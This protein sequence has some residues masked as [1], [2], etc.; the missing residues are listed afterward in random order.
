MSG[1]MVPVD[2]LRP[3]PSNIRTDL[4]DLRELAA[5]IR[6]VGLLQPLVV[7]ANLGGSSWTVLDGHRRLGAAKLAGVKAVPCLVAQLGSREHQLAI[8]L[9]AAMHKALSVREQAAAFGALR[10][11]GLA[12]AEIGRRTGYS[13]STVSARLLL[14]GLPDEALDL[15]DGHDLTVTEATNLAR[16]VH[17]TGIGATGHAAPMQQ[18]FAPGHPLWTRV[19]RGC[20]HAGSRRIIGGAGCGQCWEDAIR[21]DAL[22]REEVPA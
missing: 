8:M 12:V 14:L 10:N 16:Q 5:S 3:H 6:A 9:A 18:Y 1:A 15:V 20:T 2:R 13:P 11:Q 19:D 4:G 17:R 7:M 22:E 21:V